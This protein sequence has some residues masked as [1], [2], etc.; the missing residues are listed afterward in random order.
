MFGG[1]WPVL[2]PL[3]LVGAVAS[4]IARPRPLSSGPVAASS[5][6]VAASSGRAVVWS[7]PLVFVLLFGL[8]LR[9][10]FLAAR[11]L[12]MVVPLLAVTAGVGLDWLTVRARPRTLLRP[13]LAAAAVL[14]VVALLTTAPVLAMPPAE[15][16]NGVQPRLPADRVAAA[17][18]PLV[19]PGDL[20]ILEAGWD[21]HALGYTLEHA[22][23]AARVV[24]TIAWTDRF[25][26]QPVVPQIAPLVEGARRVW[27]V[28]W[29]QAPQA[30]PWLR[31][32]GAACTPLHDLTV[33]VSAYGGRFGAPTVA[34]FACTRTG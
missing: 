30:L 32:G 33:D 7:G 1:A 18:A 23:P 20:I 24:R 28:H 8:A 5:G 10:D 31:E 3:T 21:D 34:M 22:F 9:F 26:A 19:I 12:V 17:L 29:L 11:T 2:V 27:A 14:A 4:T 13:H 16:W 25:R 15:R 6:P